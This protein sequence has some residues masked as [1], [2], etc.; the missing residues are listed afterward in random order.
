[1][2]GLL[3][4]A[5]CDDRVTPATSPVVGQD[6]GGDPDPGPPPVDPDPGPPPVD[7]DPGPP[8]VNDDPPVPD[9]MPARPTP[10]VSAKPRPAVPAPPPEKAFRIESEQG[11]NRAVV[12]AGVVL[13]SK[14][15]TALA[16]AGGLHEVDVVATD[17]ALLKVVPVIRRFPQV[18]VRFACGEWQPGR[19]TLNERATVDDLRAVASMR[20]VRRLD[21]AAC[22]V[23]D[24][25]LVELDR[26][27]GLESL[28]LPLAASD[29]IAPTLVRMRSLRDLSLQA[30]RVTASGLATLPR[31]L[32]SLDLSGTSIGDAGVEHLRRLPGLKELWLDETSVG[33]KALRVISTRT[34]IEVLGL[35]GTA[36]T[37][38]GLKHLAGLEKLTE[39]HLGDTVID[40]RALGL[41]IAMN[42]LK[43]LDVTDTD[44]SVAA[45]KQLVEA[46]RTCDVQ[47]DV[48]ALVKA[49]D[50]SGGRMEQALSRIAR[51]RRDPD[52]DVKS[53]NIFDRNFSDIGMGI[54]PRFTSLT[55]L[56][57]EGTAVTNVG[58]K[59]L[60]SMSQLEEL[61]LNDTSISDSGLDD[62]RPLRAL[63]Q[64]HLGG[65]R[66]TVSGVLNLWPALARVRMSFPGGH[67]SPGSLVLDR[68]AG[69]LELIPLEGLRGLKHLQLD[70]IRPGDAGLEHIRGLVELETLRLRRA[71]IRGPG[72]VHLHDMGGLR[73]LDLTGNR[74]DRVT[75]DSI[76]A[77]VELGELILDHS[78]INTLSPIVSGGR[79]SLRRLSLVGT[80]VDDEQLALIP[81]LNGLELL[82]LSGCPVTDQGIAS[83]L[84]QLENL[85]AL[86]LRGTPIGD[87]AAGKL[88][89]CSSLRVLW[90]SDTAVTSR[91]LTPLSQLP[92]LARLD[93]SGCAV[94]ATTLAV[95]GRFDKLSRLDLRRTALSPTEVA[96][97]RERHAE[98]EVVYAVDPLLDALTGGDGRTSAV[99]DAAVQLV[100]EIH[101]SD[102]Q[103]IEVTV[104]DSDLTDIGLA[105]LSALKGLTRLVLT[106][107]AVTDAGVGALADSPTLRELD[108][109]GTAITDHASINLSRLGNLTELSLSDTA[110][111]DRG[112]SRLEGLGKLSS[113]DLS[114]LSISIDGL[115]V[116][117]PRLN[118]L[119]HLN[120]SQTWIVSADLAVLAKLRNLRSLA[121]RDTV[122]GDKGIASIAK[123]TS[124]KRLWIDRTRITSTGVEELRKA[125]PECE[126][127]GP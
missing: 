38:G 20:E 109:S 13:D 92:Q 46:L 89:A 95:V 59:H 106:D 72:L 62:L 16:G 44:L 70:G 83:H 85:Q 49:L 78:D 18:T 9:P 33:D 48:D 28:A 29:G 86:A 122:I 54:L 21:L 24:S 23:G 22:R 43:R 94:D 10:A 5:G 40:D 90:L 107:V 3:G 111:S 71:G 82:D 56:S 123:L 45:R 77:W 73:V 63:K 15:L 19:V 51:V 34:T 116:A 32:R 1:M 88:A 66:V 97:W 30:T 115:A 64:L 52:G 113:L 75:N 99:L 100:A 101:K 91:G 25:E 11:R 67:L 103:G 17:A 117:V 53:L 81:K 58:L 41:L 76:A 47:V 114:G 36:V 55:R 126:I 125:L 121:I 39:L 112:L 6:V 8:P 98:C 80:P 60:A 12:A 104:T 124:L 93:L 61:W 119:Q 127:F 118:S 37:S 35:T 84:P 96:K 4:L 108:L 42:Q 68:Q 102:R 50:D 105:R 2:T 27:I 14:L 79:P 26:M 74:L 7:D 120:L 65:T 69:P 57:M 87:V 110:F 31:G